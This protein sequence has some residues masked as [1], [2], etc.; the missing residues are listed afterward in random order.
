MGPL[1]QLPEI[2]VVF[3]VP[4]E[5]HILH[6]K[7]EHAIASVC[8]RGKKKKKKKPRTSWVEHKAEDSFSLLGLPHVPCSHRTEQQSELIVEK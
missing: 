8:W 3:N 4:T 5:Y 2:T 6:K 7:P 1:E